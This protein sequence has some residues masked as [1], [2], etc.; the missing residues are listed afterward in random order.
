MN[1]YKDIINLKRPPSNHLPMSRMNRAAQFAPF[2]A[3]NGHAE[4][5]ENSIRYKEERIDLSEDQLQRL[6]DALLQIQKSLHLKKKIKI[7]YYVLNERFPLGS[8]QI[9]EGQIRKIDEIAR[10]IFME[11]GTEIPL[12]DVVEI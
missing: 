12:R 2:A 10:W 5:I 11:D 6:N 7:V 3:L 1:K 8:Y 9:A 4:A